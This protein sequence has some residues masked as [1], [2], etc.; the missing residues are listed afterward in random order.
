MYLNRFASGT[1]PIDMT[2]TDEFR[3]LLQ[4]A[5]DLG[6]IESVDTHPRYRSRNVVVNGL[7]L[8]LLEWG[9]E[10]APSVLLLHGGNQSAHSWDLVS[11]ALAHHFHVVAI[12]QRAHGDT[13]WPR[14]GD[15]SRYTMAS[16]AQAVVDLLGVERPVV[17]GHS[18]GGI[19][20]MTLLTAHPDLASRAVFVDIA[21]ELPGTSGTNEGQQQ[22]RDFISSAREFDSIDAYIDRV[23]EYDPFRSREHIRR[24]LIY[25]LMQR[26]DGKYVSKN[27]L[28]RS[29]EGARPGDELGTRPTIEDVRSIACPALVVRGAQ[30]RVLTP[31]RATAFLEALPAGE[32]VTVPDCG[33]NV[34]SQNTTGF[35]EALLPF[36]SE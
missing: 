26:S 28:R 24:T 4:S 27:G 3:S 2:D 35:L 33:H 11:L 8:H 31:D 7:R 36:L 34:H 13:E 30:S 9:E 25:N 20:A 23:A 32:L 19:V 18:M 1:E 14:D 12:D 5:S 17:V 15:A 22:I 10:T 6:L 21:P 16:D 29:T